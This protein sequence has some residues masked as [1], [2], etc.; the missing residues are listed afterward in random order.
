MGARTADRASVAL[1]TAH[2]LD[3]LANSLN[4]ASGHLQAARGTSGELRTR[5]AARATAHLGHALDAGH[6]LAAHL[7]ENYP[8]E[9]AELAEL[10]KAIGLAKAVSDDA[11][12]ATAAHLLE[13]VLHDAAHAHRHARAMVAGGTAALSQ[14]N[15]A[16]GVKH[17]QGATRHARKL[18]AHLR[19]NYPN[20]WGHLSGLP[21]A[22]ALPR[23]Y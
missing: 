19:D 1:Y 11:K 14:F 12:A 22:A 16:H 15:L 2:R 8:A 5:H 18:G 3:D 4:Q 13:S 10:T 7:K 9:N 17:L 21:L 6:D 20:E 23:G